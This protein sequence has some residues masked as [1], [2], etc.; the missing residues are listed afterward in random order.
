MAD[1]G[2]R[3]RLGIGVELGGK[4]VE[5]LD[6]HL[7]DIGT[8]FDCYLTD[9]A[10][11][12]MQQH[13]FKT[14]GS[15]QLALIPGDGLRADLLISPGSWSTEGRRFLPKPG[16]VALTGGMYEE[17]SA[18]TEAHPRVE[19]LLESLVEE[20]WCYG[21]EEDLTKDATSL[22]V[23]VMEPPRALL[24]NTPS[25]ATPVC[26]AG[27]LFFLHLLG[28]DTTGHSY[29]PHP[30]EYLTN[31][32][33]V[34]QIAKHTEE[35]FL[36][37]YSD[38][39]RAYVF[40]QSSRQPSSSSCLNNLG[41]SLFLVADIA[42][43][44][45]LR[46]KKGVPPEFHR[47]GSFPCYTPPRYPS[48]FASTGHARFF[49]GRGVAFVWL[50]IAVFYVA[51]SPTP[52]MWPEP[53]PRYP[54]VL[55]P[56]LMAAILMVASFTILAIH[57]NARF[58]LPRSASPSSS[59]PSQIYPPYVHCRVVS[60]LEATEAM[61]QYY[62]VNL[63]DR[64]VW[65]SISPTAK[66][67]KPLLVHYRFLIV[68]SAS[69][70]FHH[71]LRPEVPPDQPS[72][73]SEKITE[74]LIIA[75]EYPSAGSSPPIRSRVHACASSSTNGSALGASKFAVGDGLTLADVAVAQ[76]LF[77]HYHL[78]RHETSTRWARFVDRLEGPGFARFR[79][80]AEAVK[81][82]PSVKKTHDEVRRM[83]QHLGTPRRRLSRARP[84]T[85]GAAKAEDGH[86][87][88]AYRAPA[89]PWYKTRK[90]LL[91]FFVA[92]IVAAAA[93]VGGAVGVTG[94]QG[95]TNALTSS[96]AANPGE[97]QSV[98]KPALSATTNESGGTGTS[99]ASD[100]S[101]A[102]AQTQ[103]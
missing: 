76:F 2:S 79:E 103:A 45:N 64:S 56:F 32:Q 6:F 53:L 3:G 21:E 98:T 99:T 13:S 19:R 68:F 57:L 86:A 24:H 11:Q 36:E 12:D 1:R 74:S 54:P 55:N 46:D 4:S 41:W 16:H 14:A 101:G 92:G 66:V 83:T 91:I 26:K 31:I 51:Y 100:T 15:E 28:L 70:S 52:T 25:D 18:V 59:L 44:G 93:V 61:H 65:G 33:V 9:P 69:D 42:W 96:T 90:W 60:V 85:L 62:A 94:N 50:A 35:L 48:F 10:V 89:R 63:M 40:T 58:S 29:R 7:V 22:D 95:H 71:L 88:T 97:S 80:Y 47:P 49:L 5:G 8:V 34:H 30:R 75:D 87:C 72:R 37:L 77:R 81:S 84:A 73:S 67:V 82:H 39:E 27:R 20:M 17:V 43:D 23:W 38:D 102:S 78:M